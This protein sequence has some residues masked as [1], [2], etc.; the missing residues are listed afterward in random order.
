[1]SESMRC[2]LHPNWMIRKNGECR[3]WWCRERGSEK[4]AETIFKKEKRKKKNK[5]KKK[6][7][8]DNKNFYILKEIRNEAGL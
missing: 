1:M 7:N 2:E 6:N 4:C 8:I 5:K 3:R